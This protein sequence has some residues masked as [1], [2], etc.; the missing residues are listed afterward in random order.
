MN[1]LLSLLTFFSFGETHRLIATNEKRVEPVLG[2]N[3]QVFTEISNQLQQV[4][5]KWIGEKE[6][7]DQ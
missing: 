7:I 4:R 6:Q 5:E 3:A 2:S 1:P